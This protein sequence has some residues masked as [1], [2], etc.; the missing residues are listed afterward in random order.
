MTGKGRVPMALRRIQKNERTALL[1]GVS[2]FSNCTQ[3]EL[4]QIASLT[5]R[6]DV[7]GGMAVA[8]IGDPGREF[9]IIVS[10]TADVS[11][12]GRPLGTIGPGGFFG[13]MALLDGGDRT[14]DVVAETDLELLVLSRA[15]FR[16]LQFT[17]P[18]VA[19]KML[20]ELGGRLRR[21]DRMIDGMAK[22]LPVPVLSELRTI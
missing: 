5:T 15:E 16:T 21:A 4:G 19:Y 18:T 8:R 7:P 17:A 10:G 6:V 14:A 13:E 9:C 1:R 20:V 22:E 3:R 12:N 2:L 11:R